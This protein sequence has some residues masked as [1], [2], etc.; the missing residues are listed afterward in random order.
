[1]IHEIPRVSTTPKSEH[2]IISKIALP[3]SRK[4][5]QESDRASFNKALFRGKIK[6]RTKNINESAA[7]MDVPLITSDL[8][9]NP[10]I[11]R[12]RLRTREIYNKDKAR[13]KIK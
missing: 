6:S 9:S 11:N 3:L 4:Q 7:E 10:N 13:E 12:R 5:I 8:Y 1:M 2:Q